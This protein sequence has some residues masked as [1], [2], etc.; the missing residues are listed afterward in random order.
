MLNIER[1][2]DEIALEGVDGITLEYLFKRLRQLN[3][4]QPLSAAKKSQIVKCLCRDR[5]LTFR[6]LSQGRLSA[7]M[8]D[9]RGNWDPTNDQL[10]VATA[11]D[12][13]DAA[14]DPYAD[15]STYTDENT[16]D[17]MVRSLEPSNLLDRQL[18]TIVIQKSH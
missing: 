9:R 18:D 6:Q 13:L 15:V 5:E 2:V 1:I 7:Q 11:P 12:E 8:F 14:Y 17:A 4:E 10:K 16:F 3:G